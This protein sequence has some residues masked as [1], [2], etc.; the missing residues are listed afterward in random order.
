MLTRENCEDLTCN[1]TQVQQLLTD[2]QFY[3][4]YRPLPQSQI[5][6]MQFR[7]QI[8]AFIYIFKYYIKILFAALFKQFTF[9]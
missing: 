3:F 9:D 1:H 7:H 5:I 8:I 6:L 4:S 2:S